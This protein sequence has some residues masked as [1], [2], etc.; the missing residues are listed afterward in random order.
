MCNRRNNNCVCCVYQCSPLRLPPTSFAHYTLHTSPY[1][2]PERLVL[3]EGLK[4]WFIARSL[5]FCVLLPVC[6]IPCVPSTNHYSVAVTIQ[7][8][9]INET[10]RLHVDCYSCTAIYLFLI[11]IITL[12]LHTR[13]RPTSP[14]LHS[15]QRIACD[16]I[17][18]AWCNHAQ[19]E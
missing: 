2:A 9:C 8:A 16:K 13:T 15:F 19:I 5:D 3:S 10:V 4:S 14:C 7:F 17:L 11:N 18:A 1:V 12:Q 6:P